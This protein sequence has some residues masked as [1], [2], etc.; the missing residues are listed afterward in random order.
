[1]IGKCET[2]Q[3]RISLSNQ[4]PNLLTNQGFYTSTTAGNALRPRQ[5]MRTLRCRCRVGKGRGDKKVNFSVLP[6]A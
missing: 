3:R 5:R 1:M 6:C 2:N 4:L